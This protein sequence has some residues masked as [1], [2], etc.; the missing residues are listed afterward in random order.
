MNEKGGLFDY[1]NKL[2][3]N[4]EEANKK[5]KSPT[6]EAAVAMDLDQPDPI[7]HL[8]NDPSVVKR[9]KKSKTKIGH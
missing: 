1:F 2:K 6:V 8:P 4:P 7:D 9:A 5:R 3:P